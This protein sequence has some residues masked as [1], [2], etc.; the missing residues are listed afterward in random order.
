MIFSDLVFA[1]HTPSVMS[2]ADLS[3]TVD[4]LYE[5]TSRLTVGTNNSLV[6]VLTYSKY[7]T[8][9]FNLSAYSSK[10]QLLPALLAVKSANR[11]D[12]ESNSNGVLDSIRTQIFT[13]SR[14]TSAKVVLLTLL[15]G[16]Q[17]PILTEWAA[18]DLSSTYGNVLLTVGL[19]S[20]TESDKTLL[21]KIAKD[22]SR[23]FYV[24]DFKY[25]CHI[26]PNVTNL[27]GL[28]AYFFL[29][30]TFLTLRLKPLRK[31]LNL[32]LI[33]N[34]TSI[35]WSL[36]A[37]FIFFHEENYGITS[38]NIDDVYIFSYPKPLG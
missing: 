11:T 22:D 37:S 19:D 16:P 17:I 27:I 9:H 26:V 18:D 2:A 35:S 36:S 12:E 23:A 3:H 30:F 31:T 32:I 20:L 15:Q 8:Q 1:L 13:N 21:K 29:H 24:S 25:S 4:F 38:K 5:I 33:R 14:T 10:E 6:A 28:F 7:V 34:S